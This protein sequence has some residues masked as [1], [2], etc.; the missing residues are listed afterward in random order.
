[1]LATIAPLYVF[2]LGTILGSFVNVVILRSRALAGRGASF[3]FGRSLCPRCHKTLAW[4]ELIPILSFIL[5]RSRCRACGR[6]ISIQYPFVEFTL[7]L[8]ALILF[9]PLPDSSAAWFT[10][11]LSLVIIALLIILFVIDLKT[12]LL[13]DIFIILLSV[14]VVAHAALLITNHA[15]RITGPLWGVAVGTG[16]LGFLWLITRGRGLGLGDVK[17]MLPLGALFGPL[18]TAA[19]LLSAFVIGGTLAVILLLLGRVTA[20]TAVPFGPFLTGSGIAFLLV[21]SLSATLI[22]SVFVLW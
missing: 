13:P 11:V 9:T 20:K 3:L 10:Q 6:S 21:P 19:L 16:F 5:Q 18:G 8:A 12:F 1:M 22:N 7:G 14:A 2:L 15:A 4:Y 17:L